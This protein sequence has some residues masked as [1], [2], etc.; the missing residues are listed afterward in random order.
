MEQPISFF[1]WSLKKLL[2]TERDAFVKAKINILFVVLIFALG[3]LCSVIPVLVQNHQTLHLQRATVMLVLYLVLLKLLLANKNNLKVVAH[4]M[5][6]IGL[7]VIWTNVFVFAKNVN[8]I[9][10][11]FVFMLILSAFYILDK[12]FGIFYSFLSTIPIVFYFVFPR[13]FAI[14]NESSHELASPGY[15]IIAVL[16]FIS[17][18]YAHYL[19]QKA[20]VNTIAEKETLN[21]QLQ[22][23]VK[24]ANQAASS[25][26]DFLSTMSH[27]LRTPLN[28]VIGISELLLIDSHSKE[29]EENLEILRF[30]AVNL[31]SLIN[32]ILDFN[33]LG[34]EKVEL[35]SISVNLN[36]L[37]NGM[38]AGLQFQAKQ[39]G[40]DFI[41]TIDEILKNQYIVSD[42]TRLT[43]II[44][45]LAGNAIKFT[46]K[47]TV[48]VT[49][50]VESLEEENLNVR[51]SVID[52][53]IG[54]SADKQEA[55]FE[56]FT[57]A[58]SSITR[59]FGGTGLGLAIVKRLLFLFKSNIGVQ[60]T[61]GFGSTF[62]FDIVFK[63]DK[64]SSGMD[65]ESQE[66]D[67][68]LTGLKILVAEDNQ[69]NR[70]LLVKVFNKWNNK[71]VFAL[72]GRE[73]VEMVSS[74][75]YDVVLMDLHMPV[76]DGY[77]AARTIRTIAD[78]AKAEVPIIALTASVSDNLY[79]KIKEAGMDD[80]IL[81][82]FKLKDLYSK[83]KDISI[84]V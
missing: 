24:E 80:Y 25:K 57:Q 58:S 34:S 75:T 22:L 18:I 42:P 19:F 16:N 78:P 17:I 12:G 23:A 61:A 2:S 79:S 56:P 82:P 54:I 83:L 51:F 27:E 39:K 1:N 84:K 62:F 29:Q 15:E 9:T 69:M 64:Q 44:Y 63:R 13:A 10:L 5:A 35:E 43:Q 71:P 49:L 67:Y 59:S 68:D 38:C 4:A 50:R 32:D 7:I 76:L 30:S 46:E 70:V 52:T 3:K 73:A 66:A 40:I 47:G 65:L 14:G 60:S 21:K 11:Q 45:N 48:T 53:G 37:M 41:L 31:H 77:E 28:S 81:K 6:C 72:N 8:L 20:F 26:S 74:D 36:D 55:I 33:K